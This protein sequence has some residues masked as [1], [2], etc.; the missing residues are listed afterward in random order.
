MEVVQ[1]CNKGQYCPA[2]IGFDSFDSKRRNV[3]PGE[4]EATPGQLFSKIGSPATLNIILDRC[5]SL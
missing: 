2:M 5:L 1:F 3:S 4:S